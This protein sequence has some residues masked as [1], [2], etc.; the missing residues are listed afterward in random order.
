MLYLLL[1]STLVSCAAART[2]DC[3]QYAARGPEHFED[4]VGWVNNAF[5]SMFELN[6]NQLYEKVLGLFENQVST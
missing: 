4:T 5:R 2:C 6:K 3:A 1:L